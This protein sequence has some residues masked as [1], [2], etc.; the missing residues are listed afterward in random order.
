MGEVVSDVAGGAGVFDPNI[1]R[2]QDIKLIIFCFFIAFVDLTIES[3]LTDLGTSEIVIGIAIN[4]LQ[5]VS[6][7]TTPSLL[8]GIPRRTEATVKQVVQSQ[9]TLKPSFIKFSIASC[10]ESIDQHVVSR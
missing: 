5:N 10:S 1:T 8:P 6:F 3:W 9:T 7:L 4:K 2:V